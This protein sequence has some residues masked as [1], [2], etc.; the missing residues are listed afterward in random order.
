MLNL[1]LTFPDH[2]DLPHDLVAALGR[3]KMCQ[4][5]DMHIVP[6]KAGKKAVSTPLS[7][8][9]F[10]DQVVCASECQRMLKLLQNEVMHM[11]ELEQVETGDGTLQTDFVREAETE[12]SWVHFDGEEHPRPRSIESAHAR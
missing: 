12:A 6:S 3:T 7:A 2:G 5:E 8:R 1:L 10:R 4:F 11:W 9:R